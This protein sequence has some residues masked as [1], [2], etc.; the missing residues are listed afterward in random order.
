MTL[1]FAIFALGVAV[2]LVIAKGMMQ[3]NDFTKAEL[4]KRENSVRE[5]A[6]E[7]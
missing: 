4:E 6:V 7:K 3:A 2:S 1:I 5:K